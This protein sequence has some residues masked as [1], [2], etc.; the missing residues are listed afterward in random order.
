MPSTPPL[1]I[2]AAPALDP[3][4]EAFRALFIAGDDV[5]ASLAVHRNGRS[6]LTAAG[7]WA[8]TARTRPFT[9]RTL[10]RVFSAGKPIA[11]LTALTA[12]ADGLLTLDDPIARWWPAYAHHGK[13]NTTLRQLLSHRAGLPAFS[14]AAWPLDALDTDALLADLESSAPIGPPG[15]VIAEH[16]LTYGTLIDGLL[17][18]AGAPDARTAAAQLAALWRTESTLGDGP[19]E[20]QFG[21]GRNEHPRV[22]DLEVVDP[23]WSAPYLARE[24]SRRMLDR[25]PGHL[26]PAR[27]NSPAWREASIPATGLFTTASSLARF[28][29]DVHRADGRVAT[30]IGPTLHAEYLAPQAVGHDLFV[31][32]P[33][34]WSLGLRVDGGEIGMGGIGGSAAWYSPEHDYSFAFVT[35]SLGT[36]ARVDA[37]ADA[38]E[39]ALAAAPA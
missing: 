22:A 13:G 35:R 39:A 2:T 25:P 9:T 15:E 11:A 1:T 21:V 18:K 31:D 10:S 32:G 19:M 36:F 24:S 28:Y 8:D 4:A 14:P 33:V 17:A 29:D 30:R 38:V 23:D 5:G 20:L 27:L 7:G 37:L 12:V 26:D 6:L 3:V 34:E 16:A